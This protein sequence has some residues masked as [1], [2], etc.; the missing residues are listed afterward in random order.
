MQP[1]RTS[2]VIALREEKNLTKR[3]G[4]HLEHLKKRISQGLEGA[5]RFTNL[6]GK[7][8]S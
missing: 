5:F 3:S 4:T 6:A 2:S 1:H 7:T 8:K